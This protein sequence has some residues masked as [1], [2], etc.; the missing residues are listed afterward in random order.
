MT[1]DGATDIHLNDLKTIS[2]VAFGT[3]GARGLVKDM[4]DAVCYAYTKAFLQYLADTQQWRPG[5]ALVIGGDLRPSTPRIMAACGRACADMGAPIINA[6]LTPSPAVALYGFVHAMPSVMITG[7]HIPDDRNGIKFNTPAGEILKPDEEG[8]LR[9]KV[10]MPSAFDTA[11]NLTEPFHLPAVS[12]DAQNDYVARYVDVFAGALR[13]LRV[14]LYQHSSVGRDLF[15]RILTALGAEV[16]PLGRSDTFIPVDTEA[17]RPE[18]TALAKKWASDSKFDAIVSADGDADRPLVADETGQWLRGDIL[19]ILCA[20][21]LGCTD[22]VT[23]VSSN[24]ALEKSLWFAHVLRTRIGSPYVIQ[25][26]KDLLA[27]DQAVV[28]GY[29]ANG[30]FLLASNVNHKGKTLL[31]LP[32]RDATIVMIAALAMARASGI[33]V[34][35]LSAQLPHRFT[36]SDRLKEFPTAL[37]VKKL[38]ELSPSDPAQQKL[39]QTKAFGAIC[40]DVSHV[41]QTDGLRMTF[42]NEEI[43]HLRP[44]G[45]APEL[46]CYSEAAS[47]ARA[48]SINEACMAVLSTWRAS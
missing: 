43:L 14:G 18:D 32:T 36:A 15:A 1:A 16:V 34:S 37:S 29:E 4:T 11:G 9:Q 25:G 5:E 12:D 40:G 26:M 48:Q 28:A 20:R 19:G 13:G 30:G 8:I 38:H 21:F 17:V 46:R 22:V 47:A 10:S 45:N 33:S 23:P 44:S 3:S 35:A 39:L 27:E 42:A 24:T 41:D 2:G 31:A 7:S 6:G